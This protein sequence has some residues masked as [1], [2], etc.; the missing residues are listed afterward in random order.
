LIVRAALTLSKEH[1]WSA[2]PKGGYLPTPDKW[3]N[4]EFKHRSAVD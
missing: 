3:Q 4:G 1:S 2:S